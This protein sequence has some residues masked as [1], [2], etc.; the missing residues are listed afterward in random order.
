M[1]LSGGRDQ[2]RNAVV[3]MLCRV[4][5]RRAGKGYPT[6]VKII[7]GI[8]IGSP[9]RGERLIPCRAFTDGHARGSR[10]KSRSR[11]TG[12]GIAGLGRIGNRK[13]VGRDVI[14]RRVVRPVRSPLR[15]I[16][17]RIGNKVGIVGPEIHRRSSYRLRSDAILCSLSVVVA[18]DERPAGRMFVSRFENGK[19]INGGAAGKLAP[20]CAAAG[21]VLTGRKV[22]ATYARSRGHVDGLLR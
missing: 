17:D 5:I 13:G 15:I 22:N 9:G 1:S 2:I 7:D 18:I 8:L 4:G 3:G 16:T 10:R 12:K 6:F 20:A 19:G 11:P 21:R 14:R